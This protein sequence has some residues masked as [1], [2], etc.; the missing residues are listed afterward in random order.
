[1]GAR[2]EIIK[3]TG[4]SEVPNQPIQVFGRNYTNL[5]PYLSVNYAIN[6]NN[7][8]SYSFSSRMRRPSFWELNPV[9]NILTEDNYTQ[10]NPFVK[11]SS[12]YNQELTYMF[13]NSYFLILNHSLFKDVITQVPLQRDIVRDGVTYRQLTY[14]RTNF[15]DKQEMTAMIGMQKQFFKKT[16]TTNFN[17]GFQHN[18][19]DGSLNTDPTKGAVFDTYVNQ[20]RS[21]SLIIQTNNTLSL[22]K[23]KTWFLGANFFYVDKQQIELGMLKNLASLDLS[24]KKNWNDWTFALNVNDVLSTN[25]VEIE[26]YQANGNYNYVMND[27][28]RRGGTLSITYNFG[29]QKVK[30]VRNIEGASDSIKNR[31]R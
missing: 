16:L 24:I 27:Q 2:Y 18:T 22:D 31:T 7:N 26:D 30:K 1:L 23:K 9:K 20:N 12:S 15:G 4:T 6:E 11:A 28:F 29:N 10:N 19:N 3:S 5:L 14:I 17:I 8:I 13:K 25:I 21:T